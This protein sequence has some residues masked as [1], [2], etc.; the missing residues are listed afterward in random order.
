MPYKGVL[1]TNLNNKCGNM[2]RY[3]IRE[4]DESSDVMV[5]TF[6]ITMIVT[7]LSFIA[8]VFVAFIAI[9]TIWGTFT[10]I[11][12]YISGVVAKGSQLGGTISE[13]WN[14]NVDSMQYFFDTARD[15]DHI[16]PALVKPFLVMAGVGVIVV[17]TVLLPVW[18]II[19][20]VFLLIMLPFKGIR[21]E[22]E[23]N[24]Y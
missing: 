11:K 19:H 9:G 21:K 7:V 12:N 1:G 24:V 20:S 3:V 22:E 23:E 14:G 6:I 8:A 2:T 17:G 18:I 16:L 15:Y 13:A 4:E 5:G 10:S